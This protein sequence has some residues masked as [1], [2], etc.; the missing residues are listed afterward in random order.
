MYA[1]FGMYTIFH[2]GFIL[3]LAQIML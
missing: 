1:V 2:F 3:N